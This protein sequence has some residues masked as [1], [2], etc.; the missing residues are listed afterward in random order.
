MKNK[1]SQ[2]KII[3]FETLFI[4]VLFSLIIF[5]IIKQNSQKLKVR[6]FMNINNNTGVEIKVKNGS[7][8]NFINLYINENNEIFS[9]DYT[10]KNYILYSEIFEDSN[11]Y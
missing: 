2:N 3:I 11:L 10:S 8:E 4:I 6:Y 7:D 5:F 9:F 1:I